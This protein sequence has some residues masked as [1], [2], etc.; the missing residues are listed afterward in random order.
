MN[1]R[2][3]LLIILCMIPA[4]ACSLTSSDGDDNSDRPIIPTVP[5]GP[6]G[7]D[8]PNTATPTFSAF[9]PTATPSPQPS[10]TATPFND[11]GQPGGVPT[12]SRLSF[13]S[14]AGGSSTSVFPF[15]TTNV[16]VR[17]NYS[18]VPV[19]TLM[20][21]E[22]YRDG[23]LLVS[24][25]EN[26]SNFW[27]TDGRL[28]HIN[29][30]NNGQ[31]LAAGNYYVVIRLPAY[32]TTIDGSFS[33][34]G[35]APP[36]FSDLTFSTRSDGPATTVFPYGSE[37]V[38]ARWNFSNV[39]TGT[40]MRRE[41]YRDGNLYIER[42]EP[43]AAE[44]GTSGRLTHIRTY[45]FTSGYGLEPGSY[46]V[47]IFLKDFPSVRVDNSFIIEGNVGPRLFNLRFSNNPNGS[48]Q[49]Q[50]AAGT[51][52]VYAIFDYTNMPLRAQMRRVWR[53]NGQ[54]FIDRTEL[55]DFDKYGTSG[56]VRD[57]ML[58]DY[59]AGGLDSGSYDVEISIVG[60]PGVVVTGSFTIGSTDPSFSNL[61]FGTS[62]GS[63]PISVF[64]VGTTVVV[65]RW[66]FA[67]VP[68][69]TPLN[70]QWVRNEQIYSSTSETWSHPGDGPHTATI[71]NAGG[72]PEGNWSFTAQLPQY[73]S[74]TIS[75]TFT[76]EAPVASP[77]LSNLGMSETPGGPIQTEFPSDVGNVYAQFDFANVPAG[78]TLQAALSST[79]GRTN[80][81]LTGEWSYVETGRV[82]DLW[83]GNPSGPLL[84][85]DYSLI[86]TLVEYGVQVSTR[87]TVGDSD[88]EPALID[89]Y[90][91]PQL[92]PNAVEPI[93]P[94][95][96]WESATY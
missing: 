90:V 60:Q 83:I 85:G 58:F 51:Q 53:R 41:W 7:G 95:G 69:G 80:V 94:D 54:V 67:N 82:T 93:V 11:G 68:P 75:G 56:T 65:A 19:G 12:F 92:D 27:G 10:A 78:T 59:S 47:V 76:I 17:W 91:P 43:W 9:F 40:V 39:P 52:E 14:S 45:N 21:R 42:E 18:N 88:I 5:S 30:N 35:G 63:S 16:Y 23:V 74:A 49:T 96:I 6:G 20:T 66:D 2:L 28:T 24:R 87:F 22:W 64:P 1:K 44:W 50:F 57:V 26:W 73:P 70:L 61:S 32:G 55:W 8:L 86:I 34:L 4:L 25:Q 84:P 15:G 36:S 31:A 62:Q 71:Q 33:I 89:Y 79:D 13:S 72:L 38:Y 37:E 48:P 3:L 81:T 29:Y 46:R 77:T